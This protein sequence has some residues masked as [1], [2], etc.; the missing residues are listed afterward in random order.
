MYTY[1]H[2][3]VHVHFHMHIHRNI[4][5]LRDRYTKR[6][7]SKKLRM[8]EMRRTLFWV[9]ALFPHQIGMFSS[10]LWSV[11]C[12]FPH[13]TAA[14]SPLIHN[15]N[16]ERAKVWQ[17]RNPLDGVPMIRYINPVDTWG[18]GTRKNTLNRRV[19]VLKKGGIRVSTLLSSAD[20]G[21]SALSPL[22]CSGHRTTS[23]FW[24]LSRSPPMQR[25]PTNLVS[26]CLGFRGCWSV[27]PQ[28]GKVSPNEQEVLTHRSTWPGQGV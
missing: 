16:P 26:V 23:D 21:Y 9:T 11:V 6:Y 20:A 5:I 13:S 2:I 4:G 8:K 17:P 22:A 28:M 25:A 3:H 15:H 19:Q 1:I 27:R 10:V 14:L 7:M 24:T 18:Q 12:V